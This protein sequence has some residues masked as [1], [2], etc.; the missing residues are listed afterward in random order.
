MENITDQEILAGCMAGD[1]R[2]QEALVRKFSNPVYRQIQYILRSRNI[3]S[4]QA[5]IEDLHNT[6][7][8]KLFAERCKKLRQFQGKNGCSLASWIR[9]VTI[10]T[11]LDHLRQANRDVLNPRRGALF[12]EDITNIESMTCH[13]MTGQTLT[14]QT[15][16]CLTDPSPNPL[17]AAER[18][19]EYLVLEE[20]M[21]AMNPRYRLVIKLLFF[22]GLS[23]TE[24]AKI[25]KT[26]EENVYSLKHRALKQL[27]AKVTPNCQKG[28]KVITI[29][30]S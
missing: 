10:R 4:S 8:E 24:V 9:I 26:S 14:C 19:E 28:K 7:F 1:S 30:L 17:K 25:I 3:Y 16:T 21:K 13:T 18:K 23:I 22:K 12:L 27:K 11:V 5:D 15:M 6:L 29:V 20:E 2:M